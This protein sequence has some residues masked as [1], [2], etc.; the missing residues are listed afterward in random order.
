MCEVVVGEGCGILDVRGS[1]LVRV[2]Q[3]GVE[4]I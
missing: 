2:L 3:S 4:E 1:D